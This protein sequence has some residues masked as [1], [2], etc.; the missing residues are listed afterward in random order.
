MTTEASTAFPVP[1]PRTG[2]LVIA[3]VPAG[4]VYVRH[5][6]PEDGSGPVRLPDPTPPARGR[7]PAAVVAAGHARP[8]LGRGARLRRLPPPLRLRRLQPRG[9]ARR[10]SPRC[11]GAA[12]RSSSPCTTCATPTTSTARLHDAPARRAGPG[13]RRADHPDP[14]RRRRDPPALGPRGASWCRTRTSWTAR[15]DAPRRACARCADA[16]RATARSGSG[17]TSR[18]CAPSMAPAARCCP[19]LV[20]AVPRPARAP[21]CRST[22]TATCSTPGGAAA[23]RRAGRLRCSGAPRAASSTCACTTSSPTTTLWAYLARS[24]SR[25]CPTASAPTR[26]WLEACRDLGTTVVAPTAATTP[27]RDRCS[28][29]VHDEDHFDA[30]VPGGGRAR[31]ARPTVRPPRSTW[32][33]AGAQRA[34]S[35]RRTTRVYRLGRCGEPTVRICLIASS[36]FPIREP[37][38]GGLEAHDPRPGRAQLAR[39]GHEV[40]LFAGPGLGPGAAGAPRSPLSTRSRS[41]PPRC[42]DV[43]RPAPELDAPSTTPTSP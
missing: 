9:A 21:C 35:P 24:T 5:L 22:G 16:G 1:R 31:G 6:A 28:T 39:R 10:W 30:G 8:G 19:T 2:R 18:A 4:H 29:Y 3:S 25:C 40:T 14:G 34:R 26:G 42:A 43:A 38:A 33:S 13:R 7:R 27:T 23:R 32:T 41:A 11:A 20:E 36:R 37:F 17:C 15:R 12:S